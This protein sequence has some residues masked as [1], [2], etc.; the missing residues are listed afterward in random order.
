M[1]GS[2]GPGP[3][4]QGSPDGTHAAQEAEDDGRLTETYSVPVVKPT[5]TE[6][7]TTD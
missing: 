3:L 1:V 6:E 2:P 5:R 7:T 4:K